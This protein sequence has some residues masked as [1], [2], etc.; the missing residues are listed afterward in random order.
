MAAAQWAVA[1]E[2][3]YER[4]PINY[5]EAEPDTPVTR[6]LAKAKREGLLSKGTDKE[7][8]EEFLKAL[9]VPVESQVLV[10]S[11]TSAQNSRISPQTPRALYF[12]DDVYVGWVQG[13]EIEIASFDPKLGLVFHM[14]HLT[15]REKGNPPVLKRERSCLNCHAGSSNHHFPGL[16]VRSVF[17]QNT[18]QPL[19]Q[20][21]TFHTRHDS[22]IDERWGG[23]YVSGE[24]EDQ[25]HM[26]NAVAH[27][28]L[29]DVEIELEPMGAAEASISEFFNGEP[30]L[31]GPQSDVVALMVLE[32]QV[33]VHNALVEA[34][35]TTRSTLY[36]HSE[37]QKAFGE[38]P[39]GPLSETNQRVLKSQ[40]DRVL[41]QL[42]FA[43]EFPLPAGVEGSES[44]Q[45]GFAANERKSAEGR[46]LKDFRLYERLMKYR[47]SHLIYC[48]AFAALPRIIRTQILED[49][50]SILTK[51]D[52]HPEFSYLSDSEREHIVQILSETMED[53]PAVWNVGS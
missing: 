7:I 26:G 39:D 9:E 3:L 27:S 37:M 48:D 11:K 41:K 34:N 19:F 10:F 30:Y 38:S 23:W 6:L 22:P 51:P 1:F 47:C 28:E 32:H 42:L 15:D 18:G 50:H 33:G 29:R 43:D 16:M 25:R 49:L 36:R 8:L 13:G 46:S 45:L 12:S 17:P 53:L 5:H 24:V 31:N 20:A 52:S 44:F 35:L 4:A 21:G 2:P 14:L 40:S